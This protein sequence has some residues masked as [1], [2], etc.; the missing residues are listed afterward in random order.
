MASMASALPST[1]GLKEYKPTD[2]EMLAD[3]GHLFDG[4][5]VKSPREYFFEDFALGSGNELVSPFS[6]MLETPSV[7]DNT[8][9][10]LTDD[11][12]ALLAKNTKNGVQCPVLYQISTKNSPLRI[13]RSSKTHVRCWRNGYVVSTSGCLYPIRTNYP[14]TDPTTFPFNNFRK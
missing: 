2:I 14:T 7:P 5:F 8:Y 10:N 3:S 6:G 13:R 9:M 11:D 12:L 1:E 4:E